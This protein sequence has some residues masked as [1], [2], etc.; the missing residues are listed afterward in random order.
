VN[1]LLPNSCFICTPLSNS[2]SFVACDTLCPKI[3]LQADIDEAGIACLSRTAEVRMK[4]RKAAAAER[5]AGQEAN[6]RKIAEAE[7][8]TQAIST[9]IGGYAQ[10]LHRR[11]R[12]AAQAE[13]S[14][15]SSNGGRTAFVERLQHVLA[16]SGYPEGLTG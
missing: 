15:A 6:A 3:P 2:F 7:F 8:R 12:H 9:R 1:V 13:L 5:L 14:P 4:A 16:Q 10:L 11:N